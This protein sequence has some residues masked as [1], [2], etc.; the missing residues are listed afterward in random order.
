[1]IDTI[2]T[3]SLMMMMSITVGFCYSKLVH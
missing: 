2:K 3:A 1:V